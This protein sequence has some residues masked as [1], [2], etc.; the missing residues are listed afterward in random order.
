MDRVGVGMATSEWEATD[1]AAAG[2]TLG[3]HVE[4]TLLGTPCHESAHAGGSAAKGFEPGVRCANFLHA[5]DVGINAHR[6]VKVIFI[7][8]S[9]HVGRKNNQVCIMVLVAMDDSCPAGADTPGNPSGRSEQLGFKTERR[10]W[11]Q[12]LAA[13]LIGVSIDIKGTEIPAIK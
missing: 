5:N 12:R 3:S 11:R 6:S 7:G 2:A 10:S 9:R 13:A 4:V 8:E 1:K